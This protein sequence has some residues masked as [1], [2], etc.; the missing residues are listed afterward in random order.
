[1]LL[2]GA[3][4]TNGLHATG[5]MRMLPCRYH[6]LFVFWV[7]CYNTHPLHVNNII[8]KCVIA[9]ISMFNVLHPFFQLVGW[10]VVLLEWFYSLRKP[11]CSSDTH[12]IYVPYPIEE[13][14]ISG[15]KFEPFHTLKNKK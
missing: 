3:S 1:M 8:H 13:E 2:N 12:S 10:W 6:L 15:R 5:V 11:D 4:L 9:F 14:K 7:S